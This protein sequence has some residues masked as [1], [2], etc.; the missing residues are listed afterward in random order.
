MNA[1]S[2]NGRIVILERRIAYLVAE[3]DR[4]KREDKPFSYFSDE[5]RALRWALEI[6]R[7]HVAS[8]TEVEA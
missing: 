4:R 5:I 3:R 6:V 1:R 2:P 8:T 7:E